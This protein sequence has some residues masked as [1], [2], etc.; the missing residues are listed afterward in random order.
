MA[1]ALEFDEC[2][3]DSPMF[4]ELL[5]SSENDTCALE[6]L[7]EKV[8]KQYNYANEAE[9][10]YSSAN[11]MLKE[12]IL[13]LRGYYKDDEFLKNII[14]QFLHV[15]EEI[16][17]F[18]SILDQAQKSINT[19]MTHF[20]K[21]DVKGN[22][23]LKKTFDKVSNDFDNALSK[24]ASVSRYKPHEI[25][26]SETS[27]A[28]HKTTFRNVTMEYVYQ[29]NMLHKNKRL[30][31]I[32]QITSCMHAFQTYFHQGYELFKDVEPF[33]KKTADQV[34]ELSTQI[35]TQK[36]EMMTQRERYQAM[37]GDN[38]MYIKQLDSSS[39]RIIEGY[40]FKRA[41]NAFKTWSRRWFSIH[42]NKLLYQSKLKTHHQEDPIVV[43]DDLRLCNIRVADDVERRF[44]FEVISPNKSFL[45][46]AESEDVRMAWVHAIQSSIQEAYK[47]SAGDGDEIFK[48]QNE[49]PSQSNNGFKNSPTA[50]NSSGVR[51][52]QSTIR[53]SQSD[54]SLLQTNNKQSLLQKIMDIPGNT[55]CADCKKQEARWASVN[56]GIVLCIECSGAHRSLGVHVSKVRS[57]TLDSWEPEVIA[58]MQSLGNDRVNE[59]Y[60]ANIGHKLIKPGCSNRDRLSFI[61]AKYVRR[62]FCS[63]LPDQ[64]NEAISPGKKL[65]R[66]KVRKS[67]PRRKR[68]K[69]QKAESILQDDDNE[70]STPALDNE[71]AIDGSGDK[72]NEPDVFVFGISKIPDPDGD[73]EVENSDVEDI[74]NLNANLLF[75]KAA[76]LGNLPVMLLAKANAANINWANPDE[77]QQTPLMQAAMGASIRA[78]EFLL[79]NGAKIN[80]VDSDGRTALHYASINNNTGV[81]CQFL[82]R[83]ARHDIMD[84]DNLTPL[85]IAIDAANADIVTLIRLKQMN[86]EMLDTDPGSVQTDSLVTDVFRDFSHRAASHDL[87]S[88]D[89][90]KSPLFEAQPQEEQTTSKNVL[91]ESK[92]SSDTQTS[93]PNSNSHTIIDDADK[94]LASESTV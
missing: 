19:R 71:V 35:E 8:L 66:W 64:N 43:V 67:K 83:K 79:I 91:D 24:H 77:N 48:Q 16:N 36:T 9:K 86:D 28:N 34:D 84:K 93:T 55:Y 90:M 57:L 3:K 18:H 63:L 74:A 11:L 38:S 2:V 82:K 4:R 58:I 62:E 92:D 56:L 80:T 46:Q 73:T 75:Y 60:E 65:K 7:L 68:E 61:Q 40:L 89:G 17:S 72:K 31:T 13:E 52:T 6:G 42:N 30:H 45:L 23:D 81:A 15:L 10:H 50:S 94:I 1:P 51:E 27:L 78:C 76:K 54:S 5:H 47:S 21:T 44:C 41:S 59:I 87:S 70:L 37:A 20:L 29:M 33:L 32:Y 22:Q 88:P 25:E 39:A 85:Q 14:N 26:E 69:R 12:V 49:S 53:N